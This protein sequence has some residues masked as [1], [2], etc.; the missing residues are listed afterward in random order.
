M[1]KYLLLFILGLLLHGLSFAQQDL[2]VDFAA[3]ASVSPG[4]Q[5]TVDVSVNKFEELISAQWSINW[6]PTVMSFTSVSNVTN[7]LVDFGASNIGNPQNASGVMDGQLR[8]SWSANN[9]DDLLTGVTIPDGTILFSFTLD[10]VGQP[11]EEIDLVLSDIPLMIEVADKDENVFSAITSGANIVIEGSDCTGGGP[12]GDGCALVGD[13]NDLGLIAAELSGE[14]DEQI[15]VP[16]TVANWNDIQSFQFG[17]TWDPSVITYVTAQNFGISGLSNSSL[18]ASNANSGELKVVWFDGTGVSPSNLNDG[19]TMLELCFDLTGS[20][21]DAS[22]ILFVSLSDLPIE[23]ADSNANPQDFYTDC[24]EIEI[25]NDGGGGPTEIEP[26]DPIGNPNDL[27]LI[28]PELSAEP[29]ANICLPVSTANF[30]DIQ[31]LQ[32][33]LTWN[34]SVLSYTGTQNYTSDLPG[35][36]ASSFNLNSAGDQLRVIWSDGTAVTP[37]NIS[38][39]E[40]LF[41]VCFD[42]VGA[43]GTFSNVEIVSFPGFS[44]EIADSNSSVVDV[45]TD[46]GQVEVSGDEPTNINLIVN[47]GSGSCGDEICIDFDVQNFTDI[48]SMQFNIVWDESILRYD[49]SSDLSCFNNDMPVNA[50]NFGEIDSGKL[51]FS[52]SN[53]NGVT[54][55]DSENGGTATMFCVCFD[56]IASDENMTTSSSITL[57]S[58]DEIDIEI[59]DSGSMIVPFTLD[60]GSITVDTEPC[61]DAPDIT[62]TV[63][64]ITNATCAGGL[65]S[66]D[67]SVMGGVGATSCEWFVKSTNASVTTTCDLIAVQ[68]EYLLVVTD[69]GGNTSTLCETIAGPAPITANCEVTDATCDTGGAIICT[70]SGGTGILDVV[71]MGPSCNNGCT[72]TSLS[73]LDAGTYT[74]VITDVNGCTSTGSEIIDQAGDIPMVTEMVDNVDCDGLGRIEL[75]SSISGVTYNWDPAVSTTNV[76]ENLAD[77]QYSYTVTDPSTGCSTN[78][79]VTVRSDIMDFSVLLSVENATCADSED[80]MIDLMITGGCPDYAITIDYSGAIIIGSSISNLPPGTYN[81]DVIDNADPANVFDVDVTIDG[82]DALSIVVDNVLGDDGTASGAISTTVTGGTAPY[83]FNWSGGTCDGGC[84]NADDIQS[85]EAGTYLLEVIDAQGCSLMS[86]DIIIPAPGDCTVSSFNYPSESMNNGFGLSCSGLSGSFCDGSID[87]LLINCTGN[88][89][90]DLQDMSGSTVSTHTSFPIENIC[91]G[92]Y[93]LVITDQEGNQAMQ[94]VTLTSPDPISITPV[95]IVQDLPGSIDIDVTGGVEPYEYAWNAP[96]SATTQDVT[97]LDIG[98]YSVFVT[99]ANGCEQLSDIY[100][101]TDNPIQCYNAI[102]AIT[103]NND[104][105]NDVFMISCAQNFPSTLN[106]YDR[107]GRLVYEQDSYDNTWQ[108]IGSDGNPL[109]EGAYY[110]VLTVEFSNG[111]NRLFRGTITL[112]TE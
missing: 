110:W 99:D 108:G 46:C 78:A 98:S 60:N 93:M 88:L 31:S 32:F 86:S 24:G 97:G 53:S 85:L 74:Y 100:Q 44:I 82:P 38:D 103:A 77:G 37:A 75:T 8:V 19:D 72:G 63:E 81:I 28:I 42:V 35:L 39:G 30:A 9:F 90:I 36:A 61:P 51:R 3:S 20:D 62:I 48:G 49:D 58:D 12:G 59:A 14:E 68:G 23:I 87:A 69:S 104:G 54:L 1:Q 47:E 29:N 21:G 92:T 52:W 27:S 70:L 6:D 22:D 40:V 67:V 16:V 64:N 101:I 109:T 102:S 57:E 11:C 84:P 15:C 18:N 76:A 56:I 7:V 45:Y 91:A 33:G 65:G 50:L 73:A 34:T 112:L 43:L 106:V 2:E 25:S 95:Q 13:T 80:G 55:P 41:E 96:L 5:V 17:V 94:E 26:C 111:D 66:I 105:I 79:T 83:T 10:A 71:W 4:G 89:T 107:W